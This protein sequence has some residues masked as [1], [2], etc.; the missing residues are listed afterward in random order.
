MFVFVR[1][2]DLIQRRLC[3]R[4]LRGLSYLGAGDLSGLMHEI[5]IVRGQGRE[6]AY[7]EDRSIY[8][9]G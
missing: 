7:A 1:S 3:G 4:L 5:T 9:L 6:G 2:E 8:V